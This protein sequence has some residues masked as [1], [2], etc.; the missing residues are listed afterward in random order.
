MYSSPSKN[1]K[2]RNKEIVLSFLLILFLFALFTVVFYGSFA[3]KDSRVKYNHFYTKNLTVKNL[4][5]LEGLY[6]N[7]AFSFYGIPYADQPERWR[8]AKYDKNRLQ[9]QFDEN[10]YRAAYSR[11]KSAPICVQEC[12]SSEDPDWITHC[13]QL[14]ENP[15]QSEKCL[16][17]TIHTPERFVLNKKKKNEFEKMKKVPVLVWFHGGNY[18]KGAGHGPLYDGKP[19]SALTDIVVVVPNYRL[20][21]F[22][23]APY[24]DYRN[25]KRSVGNFG[26]TDQQRA[27]QFVHDFISEFGGD[28]DNVTLGGQSAGAESSYLQ[29]LSE[30]EHQKYF[31]RV[32]MMSPPLALPYLTAKSAE[33]NILPAIFDATR[34]VSSM[35]NPTFHDSRCLVDEN[36]VSAGELLKIG[37]LAIEHF[38]DK[39]NYLED[40]GIRI[41]ELLSLAQPYDPTIDGNLVTGQMVEMAES[42]LFSDK[43]II[44]GS[45]GDEGEIFVNQVLG[46]LGYED[47]FINQTSYERIISILWKFKRT[48]AMLKD[49]YLKIY[50][51]DLD[52]DRFSTERNKNNQPC[53]GRD[54]LNHA[55]RDY[56]FVCPQKKILEL[57]ILNEGEENE[58]NF[59]SRNPHYFWLFDEPFPIIPP[60]FNHKIYKRCDKMACHGTDINYFFGDDMVLY[61]VKKNIEHEQLSRKFMAYISNFVRNG[62]PNGLDSNFTEINR[63]YYTELFQ[64]Q[65]QTEDLGG[66][67]EWEKFRVLLSREMINVNVAWGFMRFNTSTIDLMAE[68][69]K[70]ED[71]QIFRGEDHD[72]SILDLRVACEFWDEA[73]RY[74]KV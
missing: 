26:L 44:I 61:N 25:G 28:P 48:D 41:K 18:E 5:K 7:G 34:N 49:R 36:L 65:L 56:I 47:F 62:D 58:N 53:N 57:A 64:K 63:N 27:L 60:Q 71:L 54:A 32:M 15:G 22:G 21:I 45:T 67:P 69:V 9:E 59:F 30:G 17:L 13:P 42:K 72:Q 29:L 20:N 33:D 16:Y 23:F 4:G 37:E 51:Y 3:L 74:G 11:E 68:Y 40:D 12:Y 66:L 52:C 10:N 8:H 24:D 38:L 50:P 6:E 1:R 46:K 70:N 31:H 19:L 39:S 2:H 14:G 73:G 55:I 35:C 43:G